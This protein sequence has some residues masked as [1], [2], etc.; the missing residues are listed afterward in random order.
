VRK[1]WCRDYETSTSD[2]WKRAWCGQVSH[3]SRCSLH[4]EEFTFAEQPR[5]ATI[6][7]AWFQHWNTGKVLW[8]CGQQYGGTVL[9]LQLL[10][11]MAEL[12]LR[13]MWTGW[14][15]GASH[16]PDAISEQRC[17][18]PRVQCPHS[19]SWNCSVV[20]WKTWRWTSTYINKGTWPSTLGKSRNWQ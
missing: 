14:V 4:Q 6:R 13:S 5:K 17:N 1:W 18:F 16:D 15:T 9:C 2:N 12:L 3:P 7:N 20:V 10:P 11:F 19:H 8:W